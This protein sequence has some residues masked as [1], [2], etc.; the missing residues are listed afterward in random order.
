MWGVG[1]SMKL[2]LR[3]EFCRKISKF[4]DVVQ[5]PNIESNSIIDYE[6]KMDDGEWSLWKKKVPEVDIDP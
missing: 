2:A 6:V 1:G 3:A 4:C 5:L